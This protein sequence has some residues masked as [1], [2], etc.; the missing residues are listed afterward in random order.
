M[1]RIIFFYQDS[2][3]Y[4]D[5]LPH[6]HPEQFSKKYVK[7]ITVCGSGGV[8]Y[9]DGRWNINSCA[10]VGRIVARLRGHIGFSIGT[11]DNEQTYKKYEKI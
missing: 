1:K 6:N 4:T 2:T 7:P 8:Y 3:G 11:F 5:T 9:P 10:N